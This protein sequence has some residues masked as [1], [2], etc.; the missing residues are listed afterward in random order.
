MREKQEF[1]E[2]GEGTSI[3]F[4]LSPLPH[5]HSLLDQVTLHIIIFST[6]LV[7]Y[8]HP[9]PD[10]L[11][12]PGSERQPAVAVSRGSQAAPTPTPPSLISIRQINESSTNVKKTIL[13]SKLIHIFWDY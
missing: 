6:L 2:Q 7:P 1:L 5:L 4:T 11:I 9:S 12:S 13:Y 10:P 3:P 8:T